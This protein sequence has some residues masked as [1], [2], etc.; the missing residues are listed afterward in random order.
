[1]KIS[2]HACI[3]SSGIKG[4][5]QV[6]YTCAGWRLVLSEVLS[7]A[8]GGVVSLSN[9][10]VERQSSLWRQGRWWWWSEWGEAPGPLY[11]KSIGYLKGV[12]DDGKQIRM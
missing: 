12:E 9:L 2:K 10:R 3:K 6:V 4:I 11:T 5:T 1:M 8:K 7:L